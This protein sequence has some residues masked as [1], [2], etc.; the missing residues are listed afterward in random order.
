MEAALV[1]VARKVVVLDVHTAAG[2]VALRAASLGGLLLAIAL[3]WY[4]LS[5]VNPAF[6]RVPPHEQ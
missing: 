4:L 5:R 6:A 3:A 2:D 1:A